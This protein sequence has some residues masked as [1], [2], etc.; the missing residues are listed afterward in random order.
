MEIG[1]CCGM[2]MKVEVTKVKRMITRPFPVLIRTDQK[3]LDNV[4]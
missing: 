4:E 2:K 3:Q 1:K